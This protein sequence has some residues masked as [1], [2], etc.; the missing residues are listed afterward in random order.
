MQI[1]T[2]FVNLITLEF[3]LNSHCF[4]LYLQEIQLCTNFHRQSDIMSLIIISTLARF[5]RNSHSLQQAFDF[6]YKN[7]M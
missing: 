1:L 3:T 6:H 2:M 5:E 4:R 7:K